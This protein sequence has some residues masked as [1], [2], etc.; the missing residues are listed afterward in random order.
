MIAFDVSP[1]RAKKLLPGK[2]KRGAGTG[3]PALRRFDESVEARRSARR[4]Q[5][6]PTVEP[7]ASFVPDI[8]VEDPHGKPI[9]KTRSLQSQILR[10]RLGNVS[11]ALLSPHTEARRRRSRE[12]VRVWSKTLPLYNDDDD[13][14]DDND[15]NDSDEFDV[16]D[17]P[18]EELPDL[19]MDSM[20]ESMDVQVPSDIPS[21]DDVDMPVRSLAHELYR[22]AS[23]HDDTSDIAFARLDSLDDTSPEAVH[24]NVE[25][26]SPRAPASPRDVS[27]G[28]NASSIANAKNSEIM[29]PGLSLADEFALLAA[30]QREPAATGNVSDNVA[31]EDG[32]D[33]VVTPCVVTPEVRHRDS[34]SSIDLST[35]PDEPDLSP[36]R[37]DVDPHFEGPSAAHE[38]AENMSR[39]SASHSN[40]RRSSID[41]T[42]ELDIDSLDDSDRKTCLC[43]Q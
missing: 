19:P 29:E 11:E 43:L 23:D 38:A 28:P 9:C 20:R 14:N 30:T 31:T 25:E 6:K 27:A 42:H 33:E 34:Q 16:D 37:S 32:G 39:V 18:P 15:H 1:A 21:A 35:L 26:E 7:S 41:M 5:P 2:P 12:V 3:T 13:D 22:A 10:G 40:R 24:V 4:T 36:I 8:R 17:I